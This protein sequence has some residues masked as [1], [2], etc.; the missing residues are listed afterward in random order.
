MDKILPKIILLGVLA[1]AMPRTAEARELCPY[2]VQGEVAV[3]LADA[4]GL[5]NRPGEDRPWR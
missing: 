2:T 3:I 5:V 4:F 1:L